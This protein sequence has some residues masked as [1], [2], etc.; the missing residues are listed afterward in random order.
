MIEW[1]IWILVLI[2]AGIFYCV[3]QTYRMKKLEMFDIDWKIDNQKEFE[4]QFT[5]RDSK[6]EVREYLRKRD[7]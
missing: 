1:G 5:T 3:W 6:E 2:S 4:Y 7:K